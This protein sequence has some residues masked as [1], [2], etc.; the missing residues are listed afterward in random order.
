MAGIEKLAVVIDDV[1]AVRRQLEE[2]LGRHGFKAYTFKRS[3]S[4]IQ[5]AETQDLFRASEVRLLLSDLYDAAL[6]SG[7]FDFA[8]TL[9]AVRRRVTM[10][11][12][13]KKLLPNAELVVFSLLPN[14]VARSTIPRNLVGP[15]FK[16]LETKCGVSEGELIPKYRT[17]DKLATFNEIALGERIDKLR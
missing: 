14:L 2:F 6:A 8:G 7:A 13:L 5:K 3:D 11:A 12:K 10:L 15:L 9:K 1:P 16:D 4:A 17:E